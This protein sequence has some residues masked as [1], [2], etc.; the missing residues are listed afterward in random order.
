MFNNTSV[1]CN[2]STVLNKAQKGMHVTGS[3]QQ[4]PPELHIRQ[5][6]SMKYIQLF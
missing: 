5:K 6:Y 3:A 2:V 4:Y 1:L